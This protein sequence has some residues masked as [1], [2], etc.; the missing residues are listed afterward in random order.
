VRHLPREYAVIYFDDIIRTF[1]QRPRYQR[2]F[3]AFTVGLFLSCAA[4]VAEG[5]P[6]SLQSSTVTVGIAV[7]PLPSADR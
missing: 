7:H 6:P 4:K 1:W 2:L 5:Q 3:L